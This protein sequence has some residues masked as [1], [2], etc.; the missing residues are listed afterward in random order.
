M[1]D[2]LDRHVIA[3]MNIFSTA[4][5]IARKLSI[6]ILMTTLIVNMPTQHIVWHIMPWEIVLVA[7]MDITVKM[8]IAFMV[9]MVVQRILFVKLTNTIYV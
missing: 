9:P 3:Q 6:A 4:I 5:A 2:A 1:Y 7:L 8:I